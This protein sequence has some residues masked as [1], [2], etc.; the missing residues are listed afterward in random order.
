MDQLQAWGTGVV[1]CS[2]VPYMTLSDGL[3]LISLGLYIMP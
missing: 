1:H 3:L 2:A